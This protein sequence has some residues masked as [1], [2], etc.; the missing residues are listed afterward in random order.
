MNN[1]ETSTGFGA[2]VQVSSTTATPM[3]LEA[4]VKLLIAKERGAR[5][6]IE[7]EE[8]AGYV[9]SAREQIDA[10]DGLTLQEAINILSTLRLGTV[11]G[12]FERTPR[13]MDALLAILSFGP[14][15]EPTTNLRRARLMRRFLSSTLPWSPS[16]Q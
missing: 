9:A 10:E 2:F 14:P 15:D 12:Q 11:Y 6:Q 7:P 13:E 16:Y 3:E 8:L 1:S 5:Q 4:A